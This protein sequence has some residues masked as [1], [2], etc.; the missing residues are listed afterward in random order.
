[1]SA[2]LKLFGLSLLLFAAYL[3]GAGYSSY[4]KKRLSQLEA[5]VLLIT[6]INKEITLFLSTQGNILSGFENSTIDEFIEK[7]G[8]IGNL[9]DAFCAVC[10]NFCLS[11]NMKEKLKA[12]FFDFGSNYREGELMRTKLFLSEVSEDLKREE[13]TAPNRIRLAYTLIFALSLSIVIIL[14]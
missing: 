2:T 12:Y 1:M 6:H 10:G 11:E 14:L 8:E 4:C 3:V 7:V 9:Y 5:F 13:Q